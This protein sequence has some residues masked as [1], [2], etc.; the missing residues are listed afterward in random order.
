MGMLPKTDYGFSSDNVLKDKFK[1]IL[2]V[3]KAGAFMYYN[4][5]EMVKEILRQIKYN[6]NIALA[7]EIGKICG[8]HLK[9]SLINS[10]DLIIPI[11]LHKKKLLARGYNQTELI[12]NGISEA[13]NLPQDTNILQRIKNTDSQ[14]KFSRDKRYLNVNNS[15]IVNKPEKLMGKRILVIDDVITTGATIQSAGKVLTNHPIESLNIL[16]FAS[17]FEF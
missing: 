15:F 4:K 7:R 11:P 5:N 3:N 10:V 16:T 8:D 12:G 9:S 17:A 2:P 13:I 14:T 6:G 1:G